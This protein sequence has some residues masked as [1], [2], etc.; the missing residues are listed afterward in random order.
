MS[1]DGDR[2][3]ES[4]S[5]AVP[6]DDGEDQSARSP[7]DAA[8]P[9]VSDDIDDNLERIRETIGRCAD[10]DL[11]VRLDED[12]DD[13]RIAAIASEF[14]RLIRTFSET[15][16]DV[17]EF[18]DQVIGASDH[19]ES[20]V[21]E[22]KATS[23]DVS[24]SVSH[25]ADGTTDQR[26]RIDAASQELQSVSA[27]TEEVASS[28][29]EAAA[30]AQTVADRGR[31]GHDAATTALE[32]L[33]TVE[34][35]TDRARESVQRLEDRIAEVE[36]VVELIADIADETNLLA[37]NASI[38]AARAGED[39]T[40]FAV[41]ANEVK[42]LAEEADDA[43]GDIEDAIEEIRAETDETVAEIEEMHDRVTT[44]VETAEEALEAFTDLVD[45]VEET[46]VAVEEISDA[47]DD[48]AASLEEIA[49]MV[50]EVADVAA[51]TATETEEVTVAAREQTTSLTEVAASVSSLEER[52]TAID[53][54]LDRYDTSRARTDDDATVL[55]FW[56]A[57]SGEKGLLVDD[58]VSEFEQQADGIR[59]E[60]RSKGSYRG[61]FDSTLSA[62]ERGSPPTIAQLYEIGTKRA[63]DSDSFVPLEQVLPRHALSVEE[64]LDPVLEYYRT[65]GQLYSMP[66]NSSTPVLYYNR[67]AFDRAG[68][69]RNRTP[70]TF[71]EVR[72]VS[73]RLVEA[74]VTDVGITFANYSWFVEQW[75]AEQNQPLVDAKNG[76]DGTPTEAY[77][78]SE[79]G[80]TIYDWI[81]GL[82]GDGLYHNPGIEARGQAREVFHAGEAGMLIDSTSSLTSVVEG[83]DFDVGT[84]YFP[85]PDERHGVVVGGGSLW[86]TADSSRAEQRA[87][88]EFLAWL[89]QP[90]QQA[91][92]HTETG[93]FPI[94][95]GA[96]DRL[97]RDGWFRENPGHETAIEQL[98]AS[99][100]TPAT[101]GARIGPFNTVRTLV[102]DAYADLIPEFGVEEGLERLNEQ[103]ELQLQRY[104][105]EQRVG[106]R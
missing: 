61:T 76:R 5:G 86:V 18:G 20:R 15:I 27:A 65:D 48:Q 40:G 13:E 22:V 91:R 58:L 9:G 44:G 57:M 17:D 53:S 10:G 21:N 45:D 37:L 2:S 26:D 31:D 8:E 90:E 73:E 81:T 67:D 100:S 1:L 14:N 93:Y 80:R 104:R 66:F 39:G 12:A 106:N 99:E 95:E 78:D 59:I 75:F 97:E 33:D 49:T 51:T 94:H 69:R 25:I 6:A 68:V 71:D 42:T 35:Q 38:Q 19:V 34:Q 24:A 43:T 89:A 83:A 7:D 16:E 87:A 96:I 11:T 63:L 36:D 64:L 70:E 56:H 4:D 72:E 77:F 54:V 3:G 55:E 29:E 74:G 47:T 102:A 28:A 23:K 41:V 30:T 101:N 62:I 82:E 88:A 105:D 60:T 98:L 50:E 85:V 46:T 32:E 103:V 84:A 79:A 52:A 92:W